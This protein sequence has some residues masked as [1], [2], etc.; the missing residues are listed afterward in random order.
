MGLCPEL[1]CE[2]FAVFSRF[3]YALKAS[4][5][6][7][8]DRCRET[9]QIQRAK[10]DWNNFISKMTLS[11]PRGSELERAV[12]FLTGDD[13]PKVQVGPGTASDDWVPR[14]LNGSSREQK[15]VDAAKRVRN[16]LFHG[17]KHSAQDLERNEKLV[18]S[19]LLVLKECLE[20][21]R[22]LA[23]WYR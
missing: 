7:K 12:V 11:A 1:A 9:G 6:C 8:L 20:Q 14:Q 19:A 16:N 21:N 3:E 17:G 2:F 15:A 5:H 13:A 18:Q 23:S 22:A 10:P 4:G